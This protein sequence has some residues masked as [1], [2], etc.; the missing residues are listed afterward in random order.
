VLG[1]VEGA[2]VRTAC[3]VIRGLCAVVTGVPLKRVKSEENGTR[4]DIR[5]YAGKSE[6]VVGFFGVEKRV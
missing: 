6:E 4:K 1:G 3:S 2:V 5:L